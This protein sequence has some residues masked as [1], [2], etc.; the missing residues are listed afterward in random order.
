[1]KEGDTLKKLL[2]FFPQSSKKSE[3]APESLKRARFQARS[4]IFARWALILSPIV[5]KRGSYTC[6]TVP[7]LGS[8]CHVTA[9]VCAE[10]RKMWTS[11]T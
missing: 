6:F 11:Y 5:H 9:G 1:M 3:A 7:T 4:E 2:N 8:T 10:R